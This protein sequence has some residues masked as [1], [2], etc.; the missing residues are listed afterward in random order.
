MPRQICARS[1][2]ELSDLI[3]Y[4]CNGIDGKPLIN[5]AYQNL[6]SD[7]RL[8]GR[9]WTKEYITIQ[10]TSFVKNLLEEMSM[11]LSRVA[12]NKKI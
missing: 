5:P 11:E 12:A 7:K 1:A 3:S 8:D 4:K 9:G 2:V 6:A 10:W